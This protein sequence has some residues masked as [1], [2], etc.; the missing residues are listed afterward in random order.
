MLKNCLIHVFFKAPKLFDGLN[1]FV[2]ALTE[3]EKRK[4]SAQIGSTTL[5]YNDI[6]TLIREGGGRL[7]TREPNETSV[8]SAAN[9]RCRP[10]HARNSGPGY[11]QCC[12]YIICDDKP[13]ELMYNMSE[14]RHVTVN[15]LIQCIWNYKIIRNDEVINTAN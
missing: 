9:V 4:Y 3:T 12:Y 8:A 11:D 5:K 13:R 15:W 6:V 10:W 14:L 7:L 2:G 1:M